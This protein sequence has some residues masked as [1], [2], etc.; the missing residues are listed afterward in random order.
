MNGASRALTGGDKGALKQKEEEDLNPRKFFFWGGSPLA[1][2]RNLHVLS[3]Q[4]FTFL[5]ATKYHFES[6]VR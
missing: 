1:V 5:R 6:S 2:S 3:R 4:R